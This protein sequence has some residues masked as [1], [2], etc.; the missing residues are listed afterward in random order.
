MSESAPIPAEETLKVCLEACEDRKAAGL[1]AYDLRGQSVL[2]DYIVICSGNSMP[3]LRAIYNGVSRAM[4]D[5]HIAPKGIEGKPESGWILLDFS[6]VLIHVF[7]PDSRDFYRIEELV[8]ADR[9]IYPEADE[10]E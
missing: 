9:K 4:K 5:H 10:E 3:H 8:D 1:E 6:D 7:H 2:A